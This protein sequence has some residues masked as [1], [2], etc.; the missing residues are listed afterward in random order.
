[1]RKLTR[2]ES[3]SGA[4]ISLTS[5]STLYTL[6]IF[7]VANYYRCWSNYLGRQPQLTTSNCNVP[8]IDVLPNEEAELWSPYTDAGVNHE[9]TQPSR[10]RNVALQ[11]SKLSE[12]SGDLLIFFY[13]PPSAEKPPS[14]QLE[15][16]KLSEVHTRLEAWKKGLPHE[17]EPKEG[18]LPQVLVMQ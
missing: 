8:K 15:L 17:L 11:I 14:K 18:Q 2:G 1:M 4:A 7:L 16:K 10:T 3:R 6:Q 5:S 12:I 9:H 13:L